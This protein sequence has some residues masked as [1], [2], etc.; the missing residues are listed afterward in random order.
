MPYF[1][2]TQ[3]GDLR[4]AFEAIVRSWPAV[5]MKKMFGAPSYSTGGTL[6]AI[7]VTGGIVLTRLGEQEKTSLLADPAAGYF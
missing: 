4:K 3:A 5:T 1:E 2:E 7:V 6:F